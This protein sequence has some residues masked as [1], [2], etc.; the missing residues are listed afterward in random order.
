MITLSPADV[1]SVILTAPTGTILTLSGIEAAEVGALIENADVAERMPRALSV[2][3]RATL[4]TE[5]IVDAIITDLAE[6]ACRLWPK[7]YDGS[8]IAF[9]ICENDSLGRQAAG[10]LA[11]EASRK[12]PG[13]LAFWAEQAATL[14]LRGLA[15]RIAALPLSTE[16]AQLTKC[17]APDG[18]VAVVSCPPKQVDTGAEALV[19]ALE[20]ISKTCGVVALFEVL[21]ADVPPFDRILYGARLVSPMMA[22]PDPTPV[23]YSWIAPWRGAPHP[24][25]DVEKK[26]AKALA[27]DRELAGLFGFN[28][29]IVTARDSRPKVDLLWTE[30]RLVVEL[31]G[32]ETH[33][34]RTA[35]A[36]DR[37]R[38]YEL[39][40]SGYVVLRLANDEITLDC[41]KALEK[42]RDLVRLRRQI[43]TKG[44]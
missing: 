13:V 9:D 33:G 11:V 24:L 8:G 28:Q 38:D 22:N 20:W 21:P 30:G 35:F 23:P 12:I 18:V 32:Y 2:T 10:V 5:A 37:H 16:M 1:P 31:D 42:I 3:I 27:G 40:L 41:E 39:I 44:V 7:W 29:S 19:R 14:A 6:T 36:R 4:S 25:S 26:L 15:P 43:M 17:I 34:S